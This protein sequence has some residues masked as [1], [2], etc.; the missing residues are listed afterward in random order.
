MYYNSLYDFKF[1]VFK[2]AQLNNIYNHKESCLD[3]PY[4]LIVIQHNVV[5]SCISS[6]SS[7]S[8]SSFMLKE[9]RQN[10]N[11]EDIYQQHNIYPKDYIEYI[12]FILYIYIL[13]LEN[14]TH[15]FC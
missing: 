11:S 15:I 1:F 13:D 7:E 3:F 9:K 5:P 4:F 6:S 8:G 10:E 2:F 14:M 12:C